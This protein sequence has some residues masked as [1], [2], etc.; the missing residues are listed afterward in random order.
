MVGFT[1][2]HTNQRGLALVS[3]EHLINLCIMPTLIRGKSYYS[4]AWGSEKDS[5]MKNRIPAH[6]NAAM[7]H[8][9]Y[10]KDILDLVLMILAPLSFPIPFGIDVTQQGFHLCNTGNW[11]QIQKNR[12]KEAEYH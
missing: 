10:S 11:T 4:K 9:E 6:S 12:V 3:T 5:M 7:F 8:K 2:P 1:N